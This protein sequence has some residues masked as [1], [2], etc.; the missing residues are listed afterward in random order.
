MQ[1]NEVAKEIVDA[2]FKVHQTL[3]PGLFESV[4]HKVLA[5]EL[6]RRRF[7]V[8]VKQRMSIRYEELILQD[9]FEADLVV[10]QKVIVELKS[11]E[12]I[13]DI[14]KKQL[15]TYLRLTNLRL[16]LLINFNVPLINNGIV[17]V[18]NGLNQDR[19]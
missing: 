18:V 2:A 14:H 17:R 12:S 8:S 15:L 19:E 10:N 9:A 11:I 13:S 7:E 3:G 1:E 16:G 6:E 5:Y 4:Y